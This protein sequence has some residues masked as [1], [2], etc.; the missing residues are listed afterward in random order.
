MGVGM[1]RACAAVAVVVVSLSL[2]GGSGAANDHAAAAAVCPSAAFGA[3]RC[4]AL[5]T[6]DQQGNPLASLSP[7]GLSPAAIKSVYS[8]PTS[9]TAGFD[10]CN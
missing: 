3:A 5:V 7:T 6:S 2:V 10:R 4:H 1:R 9:A 8:F